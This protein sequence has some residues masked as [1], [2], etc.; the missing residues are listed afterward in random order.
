MRTLEEID[1]DIAIACEDARR[2][3]HFSPVLED[4]CFELVSTSLV[5]IEYY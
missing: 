3:N 4:G 2:M 1:R 5:E